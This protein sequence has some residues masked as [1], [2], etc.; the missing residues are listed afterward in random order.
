MYVLEVNPRASRTVPFLSKATGVPLA[1]MAARVMLGPH[2]RGP[3]PGGGSARDRACFVKTPVFPFVRFQGVDTLLGPEMKST[4]EAMGA[5]PTF[6]VAFAQG[7]GGGG[8]D[9]ARR[10]ARRSSAS[11]TTT[12]RTCCPIARDLAATRL[13]A[14]RHARD[15]GVPGGARPAGRGRLQGERGAAEHRRPR[16][17]RPTSRWSSTRR[18]GARR[19]STTARCGGPRCCTACPASRR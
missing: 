12:S 1:K 11:T 17:Q 8:A 4:G 18:S 13:L 14:G 19:S 16:R 2:A 10:R 15:G 7:A 5:A 9:A 3:R 6:G